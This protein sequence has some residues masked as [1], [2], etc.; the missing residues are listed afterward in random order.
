MVEL[1]PSSDF[2]ALRRLGVE[3]GLEPGVAPGVE[4]LAGWTAIDRDRTVGG[5]MLERLDDRMLVGWLWVDRELRRRGLG[6]RLVETVVAEA[7]RRGAAALW[8]V[9]RVPAV[10][11]RHGFEPVAEGPERDRLLGTCLACPQRGATCRPM[12]V[13]RRLA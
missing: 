10:F 11:L 7:R 9:A 6:G 2:D 5:V 3:A 4:A 12:P 1:R 8:A 13:V